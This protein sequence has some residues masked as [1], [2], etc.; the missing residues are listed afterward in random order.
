MVRAGGG[1]GGG[2]GWGDSPLRI[3]SEEDLRVDLQAWVQ[4]SP[5]QMRRW[6]VRDLDG[7]RRVF[8]VARDIPFGED[9][10]L[11]TSTTCESDFGDGVGQAEKNNGWSAG[12]HG[13]EVGLRRAQRRASHRWEKCIALKTDMGN[14]LSLATSHHGGSYRS[15]NCIKP[16]KFAAGMP[17]SQKREV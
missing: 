11:R 8:E 17:L 1:G 12:A 9:E 14:C 15:S 3:S 16:A 2:D 4:P 7:D 13:V 6:D 10:A 5:G